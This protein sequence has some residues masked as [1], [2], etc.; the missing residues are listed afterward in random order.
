[1][2]HAALRD[3]PVNASREQIAATVELHARVLAAED[4]ESDEAAFAVYHALHHPLLDRA[5]SA[6][7]VYREYPVMVREGAVAVEGVIDLAFAEGGH[8]VVVDFKT[9]AELDGLAGRYQAQLA[10]YA[11]ALRK[12]K[13]LPVQCYLLAV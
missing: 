8:W 4:E 9:D 5:R 11:A 10:W 2:V 1:M 7:R 3:G 13:Q 12:T 6:A